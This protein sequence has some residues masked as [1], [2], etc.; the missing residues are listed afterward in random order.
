DAEKQDLDLGRLG[1]VGEA[2][3]GAQK[4]GVEDEG[5][6][7]MEVGVWE[8]VKRFS[9]RVRRRERQAQ[10]VDPK[11]YRVKFFLIQRI[12]IPLQPLQ[13]TI[14]QLIRIWIPETL[15]PDMREYNVGG[16][17]VGF[18]VWVEGDVGEG[19]ERKDV[20]AHELGEMRGGGM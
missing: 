19:N 3:G 2:D 1:G 14:R 18:C 15:R 17:G 6:R 12:A 9:P 13:L 5:F 16:F 11:R 8:E 4:E 20:G 10:C 7:A